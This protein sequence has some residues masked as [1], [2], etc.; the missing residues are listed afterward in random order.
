[1]GH[2]PY[3]SMTECMLQDRLEELKQRLEIALRSGAIEPYDKHVI[4]FKGWR[5]WLFW[6]RPQTALSSARWKAFEVREL[7][8]DGEVSEP[9]FDYEVQLF[10]VSDEG[11][12]AE[13]NQ[14][15]LGGVV[16]VPLT[17]PKTARDFSHWI[18]GFEAILDG[19][20]RK[21]SEGTVFFAV[22]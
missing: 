21:D 16:V 13:F 6:R 11:E 3:L 12:L 18:N 7:D 22:Y 14:F 20:G 9:T 4:V 1:M 10:F 17:E 8:F 2:T 19:H 5:R 15:V